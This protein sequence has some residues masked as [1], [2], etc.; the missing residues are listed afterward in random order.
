[1][2]TEI[3]DGLASVEGESIQE[4]ADDFD[5]ADMMEVSSGGDDKVNQKKDEG[6]LSVIYVDLTNSD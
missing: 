5:K 1:M 6:K 3:M 4:R 2:S